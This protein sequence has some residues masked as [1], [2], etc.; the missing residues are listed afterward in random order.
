VTDDALP[1]EPR[2]EDVH[3]S[4][5]TCG[6]EA[7]RSEMF[8]LEPDLLCARCAS[9]VRHRTQI[10]YR[11]RPRE[12]RPVVTFLCLGLS[13][14]LFLATDILWPQVRR[15]GGPA[16]LA[17]LYQDS[18]IWAGEVWRHL[19]CIF[20]H[21]GW[22]H[23]GMNGMALLYLGR[24]VEAG[25]GSFALLGL[26]LFTGVTG[27]AATWIASGSSVGISGALF[28]LCGFLW[29]LRRVHPVAAEVMTE[30]MIRWVVIMLILGVILS[31]TGRLAVANWA[32]GAGLASGYLAGL[33]TADARRKLWFPLLGVLAAGLVVASVY[34]AFGSVPLTANGGRT[35]VPTPRAQWRKVWLAQQ[36]ERP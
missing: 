14:A 34:L 20:L 29:A 33:A 13:I 10:R 8:G 30:Q 18:P 9:V 31:A 27:A 16:W 35:Y 12:R 4:C 6:A 3:V 2:P 36:G 22:W 5:S 7:R 1:S 28:G 24:R 32:H 19:S 25:W 23:I 11:P 15:G 21:G 17:A 26:V